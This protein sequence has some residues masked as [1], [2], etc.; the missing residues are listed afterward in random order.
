MSMSPSELDPAL[1]QFA[2][3]YL[4]RPLSAA[5]AEML[6]AFQIARE[7]GEPAIRKLAQSDV[8]DNMLSLLTALRSQ[9]A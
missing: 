1:R 4:G 2:E 8:P 5:E 6:L 3:R 7:Q 9:Q